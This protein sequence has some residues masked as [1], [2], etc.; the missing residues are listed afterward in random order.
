MPYYRWNAEKNA[1]LTAERGIS[2][3]QAVKHIERGDLL[4][5]Y[6]HPNQMLYPVQQLLVI[7][8][9]QYV[10]VVPFAARNLTFAVGSA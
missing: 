1:Q 10:C 7:R 9:G 8:V 5:V 3:E 2:F 6:E 4:D